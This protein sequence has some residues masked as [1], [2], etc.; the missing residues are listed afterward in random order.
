MSYFISDTV[1]ADILTRSIP[2]VFSAFVPPVRDFS[3]PP[4]EPAKG[5]LVT[6]HL[7]TLLKVLKALTLNLR[8]TYQGSDSLAPTMEPSSLLG[9]DLTT[10][11]IVY[12]EPSEGNIECGTCEGVSNDGDDNVENNLILRA[13]DHIISPEGKEYKL[14]IK[15]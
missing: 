13:H 4:H 5:Q 9:V 6:I 2:S 10:H 15:L 8:I 3:S 1:E 11:I 7:H 12:T 14:F